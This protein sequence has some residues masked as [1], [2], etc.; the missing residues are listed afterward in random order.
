MTQLVLRNKNDIQV[1]QIIN[2]I[3]NTTIY[4]SIHIQNCNF[5]IGINFFRNL[6]HVKAITIRNVSSKV[7]PVL[8]LLLQDFYQLES[9]SID[10][11]FFHFWD[12]ITFLQMINK[13]KIIALQ[14]N[15]LFPQLKENQTEI[16]LQIFSEFHNIRILDWSGNLI[17]TKIISNLGNFKYLESLTI[18]TDFLN[19]KAPV[20]TILTHLKHV[21]IFN[22]LN[23]FNEHNLLYFLDCIPNSI[24]IFDIKSLYSFR[25]VNIIDF[26]STKKQLRSLS[27]SG[28]GINNNLFLNLCQI[29]DSFQQMERLD[30]S[31]NEITEYSYPYF[32]SL[33]ENL[34]QIKEIDISENKIQDHGSFFDYLFT[35][36]HSIANVRLYSTVKHGT[37]PKYN[38]YKKKV[39]VFKNIWKEIQYFTK[40]QEMK[41]IQE[42]ISNLDFLYVNVDVFDELLMEI[43]KDYNRFLFLIKK[44]IHN[45]ENYYKFNDWI[46]I[47]CKKDL[48]LHQQDIQR[49]IVQYL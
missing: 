3:P 38:N 32:L 27:L 43:Q 41:P 18:S 23:N 49:E 35:K 6:E 34:P 42:M 45:H 8:G 48:V 22:I 33:L 7:L 26:L 39:E 36:K 40:W 17:N 5:V 16:L 1:Q 24:F 12:T 30:L 2:T 4:S 19:L 25:I 44:Y 28:I 11:C 20:N 14:L 9:I 10:F 37:I 29:I 46:E 47:Y 13:S 15:S 21:H 31:Y